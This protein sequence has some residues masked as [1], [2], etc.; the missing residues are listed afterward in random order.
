MLQGYGGKRSEAVRINRGTKGHEGRP[1]LKQSTLLINLPTRS[2]SVKV[3]RYAQ[4]QSQDGDIIIRESRA[5]EI[6][7]PGDRV[8]LV[9]VG[10]GAQ[11]TWK[12]P[13]RRNGLKE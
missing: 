1:R 10:V 12:I 8:S 3:K 9:L 4:K 5:K 13:T 2:R 6:N 11:E 7:R